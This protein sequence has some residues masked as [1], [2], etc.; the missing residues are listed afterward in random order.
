MSAPFSKEIVGIV[1]SDQRPY[2]GLRL[3]TSSTTGALR[4][5]PVLFRFAP[6]GYRIRLFRF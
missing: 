5:L 1:G 3:E 4:F 2:F 6:E